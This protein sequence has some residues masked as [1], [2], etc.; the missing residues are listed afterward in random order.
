METPEEYVASDTMEALEEHMV[1]V[2]EWQHD[3]GLPDAMLPLFVAL[4]HKKRGVNPNNP[5]RMM[6]DLPNY[7]QMTL[8]VL[9]KLATAGPKTGDQAAA[10]ELLQECKELLGAASK[11]STYHTLVP[12]PPPSPF[13]F[14]FPVSFECLRN[15][16]ATGSRRRPILAI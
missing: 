11:S 12:P 6:R 13:P 5:T 15:L 2:R 4:F 9:C 14:F 7:Y 8:D 3:F 10:E 1:K 16:D